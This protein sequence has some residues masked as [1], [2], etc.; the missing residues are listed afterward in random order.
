[1]LDEIQKVRKWELVVNSIFVEYEDINICITGS[2]AYLLSS[3]LSTYLA[4]RYIEIKLLPFP[5]REF[6]EFNAFIPDKRSFDIYIEY[7]GLPVL[8]K[9]FKKEDFNLI[10]N[11]AY[12]SV[13]M[14]D[15]S[16]KVPIKDVKLLRQIIVFLS[17]NIGNITSLTNIENI[18]NKKNV[19]LV[20][21]ENY[22][23]ALDNAFLFYEVGK[24]DIKGKNLLKT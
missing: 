10:I 2:N 1:M 18:L 21:I 4:G 8:T 5:F 23:N 12:S 19:H 20:T 9:P 14:K 24:Y 3:E 16:E 13:I 22:I 17:D 7:S 15:I 6:V 11:R